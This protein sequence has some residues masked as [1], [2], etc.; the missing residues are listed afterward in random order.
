[1]RHITFIDVFGYYFSIS[2]LAI[3]INFIIVAYS[4]II[5]HRD[6]EHIAHGVLKNIP[7]AVLEHISH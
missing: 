7:H 5:L 2:L 4:S 6:L 1:M 3:E